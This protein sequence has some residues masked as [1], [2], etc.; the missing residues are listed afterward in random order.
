MFT[1]H[2]SVI[3]CEIQGLLDCRIF[4]TLPS[5]LS[6]TFFLLI[7]VFDIFGAR[8]VRWLRYAQLKAPNKRSNCE[9]MGRFEKFFAFVN[10]A[11]AL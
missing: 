11:K 10:F 3:I 5:E 9:Q 1:Q 2:K 8:P 7:E 6:N 4:P